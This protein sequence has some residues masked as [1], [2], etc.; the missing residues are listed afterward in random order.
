[1]E[2]VQNYTRYKAQ[3]PAAG[4]V[5]PLVAGATIAGDDWFC[6]LAAVAENQRV[7]ETGGRPQKHGGRTITNGNRERRSMHI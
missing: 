6:Q 2:E 3:R 1:M 4:A 7:Y 5:K